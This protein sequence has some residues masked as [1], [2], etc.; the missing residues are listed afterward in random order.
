MDSMYNINIERSVLATFLFNP[1]QFH[2]TRDKITG[3]DFYLPA[4]RYM[5]EAMI[6]VDAED[7]PI[8]EEFIRQELLKQQRFDEDA[9]LELLASNPLPSIDAY[10]EELRRKAQNRALLELS[11]DI[12][13]KQ[14]N[15]EDVHDLISYISHTVDEINDL[16]FSSKTKSVSDFVEEFHEEFLEA[17]KTKSYVGYRSGI[18]HLDNIIGAF[19]PGDLVVV[20]ARPSMG[21]TSFATTVTN[22]ADKQGHGVL[23]D[24]LEMQGTQII[25]RLH[26]ER[27]NENLSD[28]R[29]GVMANPERF[30]RS[31]RELR[32]T[33]NIILHDESYISIH[34]LIAKASTVFRKNPHVKYWFID[35]LRY[36]KKEGKNIPQEISEIT[37]L[38]KKVGKEYGVVTFLLS[39]LN[40]ANADRQNKR[41]QLTDLRESG[42]VEEDAQI[43]LGLHRESYYN[44][45]DPSI[46]ESDVNPAE[47]LVLKNRDGK[48]GIASCWFDGPHTCFTCNVPVTVHD[49]KEKPVVWEGRI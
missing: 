32:N 16:N 19:C 28:I 36:I 23:F 5:Y 29:R 4:H 40:R 3:A 25:R 37:K 43:V 42:A 47:I 13:K 17:S 2:L 8:D 9:M 12:R 39:Q 22:Y 34:Q 1:E 35:H 26:S 31:L 15:L 44:R 10:L 41:P 38:I 21:K 11:N 6:I 24:S 27:A 20:C 49:Y 48:G 33:K 14:S 30:N 45:N 46:P 7:K 18:T